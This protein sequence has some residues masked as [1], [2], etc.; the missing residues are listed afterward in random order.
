[1]VYPYIHTM[2]YCSALKKDEVLIIAT[3]RMNLKNYSEWK[4]AAKDH[5]LYNSFPMIY[6]EKENPWGQ[7]VFTTG[8]REGGMVSDNLMAMECFMGWWKG[9]ETRETWRLHS[10]VTTLNTLHFKKSNYMVCDFRSIFKTNIWKQATI[11]CLYIL[12]CLL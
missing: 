9:F 5:I 2:K 1:M 12:P 10:I 3:M 7:K 4:S 11:K 8:W 6:P